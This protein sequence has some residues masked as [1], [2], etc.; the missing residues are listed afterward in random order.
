MTNDAPQLPDQTLTLSGGSRIPLLGFGT[1]QIT[2][3][4]AVRSTA[5][6]L[7]AGYRHLDTAT[8]YGNE[9][10]VGKALAESGVARDDVFVTTKCPPDNVGKELDTLKKSLELLQTDHVDL[11]LIHWPG[12]GSA[13]TDLWK[14]FIEARDAGLT[15]EIGV[16]NFD[17]ALLD[18]VKEATGEAPAINQIRWSPLLFDGQTVLEHRDR[19]VVLEGYSA[20]RGGTLDHPSIVEIAERLDRTPAQVIIRW[21]LQHEIVV[22]PKSVNADRIRSNADVGGFELSAEDMATLDGLGG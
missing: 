13:N 20:L 3:E 21:H 17:A 2:G 10:E 11:W 15:K 16:S 19:N 9:G 18:E 22:I 7:E 8:V 1:W 6:A 5:A 4:D 12:D 14:A